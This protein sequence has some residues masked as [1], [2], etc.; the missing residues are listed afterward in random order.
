MTSD[1]AFEILGIK[2]KNIDE[3]SLRRA[4]HEAARQTHPDSNPDDINAQ[5]KFNTINEAYKVLC[6]YLEHEKEITYKGKK[7][8]TYD[9]SKHSPSPNRSSGKADNKNKTQ[10]VHAWQQKTNSSWKQ[11]KTDPWDRYTKADEQFEKELR[12]QEEAEKRRQEK[13]EKL[14]R[15]AEYQ[16]QRYLRQEMQKQLEKEKEWQEN[17]KIKQAG[18]GHKQYKELFK[19]II[20]TGFA[21][22]LVSGIF[23]LIGMVVILIVDIFSA[24]TNSYYLMKISNVL[25]GSAFIG[26]IACRLTAFVRQRR[27]DN[28]ISIIVFLATLELGLV[29]GKLMDA[30]FRTHKMGEFVLTLIIMWFYE[31][32]RVKKAAA[33]LE[34][35]RKHIKNM[36]YTF[37]YQFILSTIVAFIII[38]IQ[39]VIS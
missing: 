27:K 22:E 29:L 8:Y 33:L 28:I 35:E 9:W 21:P 30:M 4:F 13:L 3:I 16:H 2:D 6:I 17:E 19:E 38:F 39:I 20:C 18:N 34:D 10:N 7:V 1:Q 12:R 5:T 37:F 31:M 23:L 11:T 25:W 24:R 36:M 26:I 14:K 32:T 15:E